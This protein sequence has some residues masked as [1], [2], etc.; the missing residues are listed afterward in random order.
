MIRGRKESLNVV[1]SMNNICVPKEY[2]INEREKER[3]RDYFVTTSELEQ[4]KNFLRT[5]ISTSYQYW[6]SYSPQYSKC[7]Q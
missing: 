5:M 7:D 2:Y 3:E 6:Q 4:L 1:N